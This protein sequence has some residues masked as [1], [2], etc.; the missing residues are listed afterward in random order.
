M[1]PFPVTYYTVPHSSPFPSV[2]ENMFFPHQS[3]PL[4]E[5]SLFSHLGHTR[6]SSAIWVL[7]PQTSSYMLS[8]WWLCVW[9]FLSV[10]IS[11]DCWSSYIITLIFSFFHHSSNLTIG[12]S[13][14]SPKVGC[15]YLCLSHL[16]AIVIVSCLGA[17][18][19]DGSQVKLITRPTF[20]QTLLHF[21]PWS[22]FRLEQLLVKNFASVLTTPFPQLRPWL[23]T[24]GR[25]VESPLPTF[26]HFI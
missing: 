15:K 4:S 20:P 7:R 21:H 6:Q 1:L 22:S 10:Q 9:K 19:W 13:N 26:G 8:G 3:S 2:S 11:W 16:A 17:S 12:V 24:G 25:L 5:S 23:S 18:S 14:F